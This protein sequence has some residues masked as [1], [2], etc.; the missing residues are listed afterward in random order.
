[1]FSIIKS[2]DKLKRIEVSNSRRVFN[3]S[4]F[5]SKKILKFLHAENIAAE[6]S[7]NLK[8]TVM[9]SKSIVWS[10]LVVFL[11]FYFAPWGFYGVTAECFEEHTITNTMR[12]NIFP[13]ILALGVLLLSYAFVHIFHKWSG[14]VFS[15]KNGFIFGIWVALLETEDSVLPRCHIS[16]CDVLIE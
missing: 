4:R 3:A 11:F 6:E 10:T 1:M 12:E 13:G 2:V 9:F 15:N 14:G 5:V 7:I 8:S 16:K